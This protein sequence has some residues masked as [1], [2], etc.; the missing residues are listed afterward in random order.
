MAMG[1]RA[2]YAEGKKVDYEE[3]PLYINQDYDEMTVP[4]TEYEKAL[5]EMNKIERQEEF[6]MLKKY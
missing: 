1:G 5:R 3:D 4:L 2:G 6:E